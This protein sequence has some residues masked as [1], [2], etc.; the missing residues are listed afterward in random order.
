MTNTQNKIMID[1]Q[2]WGH[3]WN[4]FETFQFHILELFRS[5]CFE[6]RLFS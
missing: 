5:S 1:H 3:F 6:F 4:L 2:G